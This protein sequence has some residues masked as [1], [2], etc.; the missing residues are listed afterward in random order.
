MY[1][2]YHA[3]AKKLIEQGKLEKY[4]VLEK[5]NNISPALVLF[6]CNHKPMPIRKEKWEEYFKLIKSVY[7]K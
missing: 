3:Q 2:N 5:W 4:E 1:Y 7:K 6:F